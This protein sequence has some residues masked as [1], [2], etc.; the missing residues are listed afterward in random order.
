MFIVQFESGVSTRGLREGADICGDFE[1]NGPRRS[2]ADRNHR[3][4]T[5]AQTHQRIGKA[6]VRKR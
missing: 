2:E 6:G 3:L 1:R 5:Q 4:W